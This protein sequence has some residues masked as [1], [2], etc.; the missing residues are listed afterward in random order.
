[1]GSLHHI[2]STCPTPASS[3]TS[4]SAVTLLAA[5]S[6]SSTRTLPPR[7]ART[8]VLSAL[9]RR[10]WVAR[11]RPSTTRAAPSTGSSPASCARVATSPAVTAVVA[12]P[13]TVPSSPMRTSRSSTLASAPCPWPTL[14]QHQRLAVLHLHCRDLVARWQAHRVRQ[15]RRGP[16]RHQGHGEGRLPVWCH[17]QE[18]HHR[19]LRPALN[20]ALLPHH[21]RINARSQLDLLGS[22]QLCNKP[23]NTISK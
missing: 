11:A 17:L 2:S 20:A 22:H 4:P 18:G 13:S 8:S 5:S 21:P 10:V 15:G 14:A 7:P 3:S 19:R 9:V 6:S 12:S 23:T 16:R 1:M